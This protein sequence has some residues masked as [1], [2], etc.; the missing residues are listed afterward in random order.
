MHFAQQD[1]TL[2]PAT[3]WQERWV[4]SDPSAFQLKRAIYDY[5]ILSLGC[6]GVKSNLQDTEHVR[7]LLFYG[8]EGSGKTLM[9]QA[10]AS[11]LGALFINLSSLTIGN[12]FG[13]KEGATRL[14]HM[15]FTV[16]KEK[17]YGPVV[18]YLDDCH[19]FFLGKAKKGAGAD[20]IKANLQRFQKDLLIY[21]NQALNNDDRVLV[22]GCTNRPDLADVKL[23][24]WKGSKGKPEKQGFFERSLY[25][26]RANH[27]DRFMLW[28]HYIQSRTSCMSSHQPAV[29]AIDFDALAV[30]SDGFSAA[31]IKGIVDNVLTEDRLKVLTNQPLSEHDFTC[32]LNNQRQL[33]DEPLLNFTRQITDLDARWKALKGPPKAASNKK[34]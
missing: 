2:V 29:P 6:E 13:G 3:I 24:R 9:A 16:A 34:K 18:I 26:P 14:V 5:C 1:L 22:I 12:S 31:E 20:D 15:A 8:P 27:A 30:L 11:E 25:F 19:E 33:D 7:S 23:L 17:S 10:I 21:K 32:H 28:R 4:P